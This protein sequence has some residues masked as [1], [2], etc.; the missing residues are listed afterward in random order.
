MSSDVLNQAVGYDVNLLDRY[1]KTK[2]R[3][4]KRKVIRVT[5]S[6][7][8]TID[9][10]RKT[11]S[12]LRGLV[13]LEATPLALIPSAIVALSFAIVAILVGILTVENC[14]WFLVGSWSAHLV[15]TMHLWAKRPNRH[16]SQTACSTTAQVR[17][18]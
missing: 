13:N 11:Q 1:R 4:K 7:S 6:A 8:A 17:S 14:I 15:A 10:G 2:A 5:S 18:P 16:T 3:R 9:R 12:L